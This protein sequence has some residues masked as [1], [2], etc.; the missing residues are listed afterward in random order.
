MKQLYFSGAIGDTLGVT[1]ILPQLVTKTNSKIDVFTKFP[2]LFINNPYINTSNVLNTSNTNIQ[3]CLTYDCN[4]VN[5]YATQLQLTYNKQLH[6]ELYLTETEIEYAKNELN[7]FN[8]F[9]KIAVCLYSS[10]DCKDL[11]YDNIRDLLLQIK[12]ETNTKL[13][14]FGTKMPTDTHKVFDKFVVGQYA[15]GLRDVFSLMNEC[16]LYIGVDT[17]LF[18]A[19]AALN[20][21]QVVFFKNNGCS[22]N[23]YE[24]TYSVSSFIN[25]PAPCYQQHVSVC[26]A[27]QRCMDQF[28]LLQYHELIIKQLNAN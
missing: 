10:A 14:F 22:N 5:H 6:P 1:A 7:E 27:P 25:C 8:G 13:I 2:E 18:H 24:N 20:I 4:I 15:N 11:R 23:H 28:D 12:Q 19:A 26:N 9:K 17:G 16:C 3:P 21:P